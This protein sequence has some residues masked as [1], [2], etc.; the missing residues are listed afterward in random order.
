MQVP[1]QEVEIKWMLAELAQGDEQALKKRGDSVY[2][3]RNLHL[4]R[5]DGQRSINKP[6]RVG[7]W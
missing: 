1:V 6:L 4:R 3:G 5:N 2:G 7:E